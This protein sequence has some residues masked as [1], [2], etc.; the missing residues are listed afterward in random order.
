MFI[1]IS[2]QL[3]YIDGDDGQDIDTEASESESAQYKGQAFKV[4][5]L[6][7]VDLAGSVSLSP[8]SPALPQPSLFQRTNNAL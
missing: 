3:E 2:E 7:L 4:G 8:P 5:K 6:N 1:I